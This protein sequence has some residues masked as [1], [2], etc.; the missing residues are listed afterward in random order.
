MNGKWS[1]AVLGIAIVVALAVGFFASK[2]L[3]FAQGPS[4]S[5]KVATQMKAVINRNSSDNSCQQYAETDF[6]NVV[7]YAF[8]VLNKEIASY[9]M[10]RW[11]AQGLT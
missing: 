9:G 8:P 4:P 11:T 10:A 5:V 1:T 6:G 2:V 3:N 7:K